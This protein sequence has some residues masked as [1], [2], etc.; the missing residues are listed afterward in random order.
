MEPL[1]P[2]MDFYMSERIQLNWVDAFMYCKSVGMRLAKMT[3]ED[4]FSNVVAGCIMKNPSSS[5]EILFDGSGLSDALNSSICSS[6]DVNAGDTRKLIKKSSCT[7][8]VHGFLC[9]TDNRNDNKFVELE[10]FTESPERSSRFLKFIG[11]YG[12]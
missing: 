7:H 12:E 11:D 2:K 9:E 1:A 3:T 5:D 10:S 6:I 8:E 4:Q